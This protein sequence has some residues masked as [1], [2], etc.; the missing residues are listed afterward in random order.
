M[1]PWPQIGVVAAVPS[2][3]SSTR[4]REDTRL[5]T[6]AFTLIELV[7]AIAVIIAL[8]GLV[9]GTSGYVINKGKRSRA[10]VEIAAI[11]VALENYRTDNGMY[12]RSAA[13]DTLSSILR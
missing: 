4:A 9:L 8:A 3:E 13:S 7:V 11:S 6:Y 12:P 10:E 2:R 5:Y 1:R